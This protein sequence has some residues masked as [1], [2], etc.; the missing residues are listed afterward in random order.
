LAGTKLLPA[1]LADSM[2]SDSIRDIV[3]LSCGGMVG[4]RSVQQDTPQELPGTSGVGE[5]EKI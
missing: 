4:N 5:M 2:C 1:G 3:P